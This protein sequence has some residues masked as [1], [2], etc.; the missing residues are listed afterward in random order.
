[1]KGDAQENASPPFAQFSR[2][3][4]LLQFGGH[5]AALPEGDSAPD[6]SGVH[7]THSRPRRPATSR[8]CQR[9]R[10][11]WPSTW[12]PFPGCIAHPPGDTPPLATP[13]WLPPAPHGGGSPA[14]HRLWRERASLP[15]FFPFVHEQVGTDMAGAAW[16]HR[17][18]SE[19]L[20]AGSNAAAWSQEAGARGSVLR[21]WA[22]PFKLFKRKLHSHI[23]TGVKSMSRQGDVDKRGWAC[24]QHST[25]CVSDLRRAE[26]L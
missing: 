26:S 16:S 13:A 18:G 20:L 22:S 24:V 8:L 11:D 9:C 10:R 19:P 14:S 6:G 21:G 17:E 2:R 12:V 25:H 15:E 5:V 1:M 7:H 4:K 23:C 3:S